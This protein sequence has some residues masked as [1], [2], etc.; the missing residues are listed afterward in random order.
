MEKTSKIIWNDNKINYSKKSFSLH[1][2]EIH[3]FVLFLIITNKTNR[4]G[5][6]LQ[7]LKCIC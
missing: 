5:I 6:S 3:I 1:N 2:S 7:R 4:K